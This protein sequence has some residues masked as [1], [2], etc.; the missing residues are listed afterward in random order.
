MLPQT[1]MAT[2]QGVNSLMSSNKQMK[3]KKNSNIRPLSINQVQRIVTKD[4]DKLQMAN[5]NGAN[6]NN[7]TT[8]NNQNSDM[9]SNKRDQ[10]NNSLNISMVGQHLMASAPN[11]VQQPHT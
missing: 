6:S 7:T 1:G 4:D 10:R 8:N 2:S 5:L 9:R 11:T 3:E